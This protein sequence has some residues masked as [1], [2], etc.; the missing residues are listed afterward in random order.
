[1]PVE[2][3]LSATGALVPGVRRI[4]VLRANSIG[5]FVLSLPALAALRAAYPAAEITVLGRR[6][7]VDWLSG[8]PGPWDRVVAVPAY[9]GVT[10]PADAPRSTAE[11]EA[12]FAA[13]AERYDL[14]VQLHGGGAHSNPFVTG[15]RAGLTV[16]SR[17]EGTPPLD[18]WTAY[19]A[20]QH[21]VLRQLEI[22]CLVGAAPVGL[23][24]CLAVTAD[25][26]AEAA[27][28]LPAYDRPT[29]AVHP[30]ANDARRRWPSERFA[31]VADALAERGARVVLVGV[32]DEAPL[33]AAVAHSLRTPA[34]DL[35]GRLSLGGLTGLLS[36]CA[37]V[38]SNDSGPRHIAAAAGTA[39]VSVYSCANLLSFGPLTRRWH[40]V[41]V[42]LRTAC[43]AC[44]ADPARG[45]RC[46][47]GESLVTDVPVEYV[48]R[49][50]LDLYDAARAQSR[51]YSAQ[52]L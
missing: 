39:T 24:P 19:P 37:L 51:T 7:H 52:S 12:F 31:A 23:E 43:P 34:V 22:V 16:G 15:L 30:G 41:A 38:V 40:R 35:A 17:D 47:H 11:V 4:A 46:E 50:A 49:A 45:D 44:G 28:E 3:W 25:D 33:T 6:L 26:L 10:A 13:Q 2:P 42:S 36:A 9:P 14:A 20:F 21:E 8:R 29:V 27:A 1:M 48:R 32:A 5:D 18:R